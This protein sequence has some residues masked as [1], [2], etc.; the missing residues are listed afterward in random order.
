MAFIWFGHSQMNT[1]DFSLYSM[2][3]VAFFTANLT[4]ASILYMMESIL[5]KSENTI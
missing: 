1:K 3:N 2:A 4:F 5:A